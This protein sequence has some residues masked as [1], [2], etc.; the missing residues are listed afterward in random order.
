MKIVEKIVGIAVGLFVA[1]SI[2]PAALVSLANATLTGVD[3]AVITI[4]TI[5]LPILA[6]VSIA[7]W[8]LRPGD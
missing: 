7:L 5:L 1:A 4:V 6:V 8:F 3:P 2:V